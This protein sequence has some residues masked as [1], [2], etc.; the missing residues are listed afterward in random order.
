MIFYGWGRIGRRMC[1]KGF[2]R[3]RWTPW[4]C[5]RA[6]ALLALALLLVTAGGDGTA[7]HWDV[8]FSAGLLTAACTVADQSLTRQRWADYAG[9]QPFQQVCPAS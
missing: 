9:T 1:I 8:R 4:R 6:A 3:N 2:L 5:G 7:R